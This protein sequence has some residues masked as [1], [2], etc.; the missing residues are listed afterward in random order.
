MPQ[1]QSPSVGI[2]ITDTDAAHDFDPIL[3]AI[4]TGST[5]PARSPSRSA[6]PAVAYNTSLGW[7]PARTIIARPIDDAG[8]DHRRHRAGLLQLESRS[9]VQGIGFIAQEAAEV[10]PE[11]VSRRRQATPSTRTASSCGQCSDGSELEAIL[12]AEIKALRARVAALEAG[13][14]RS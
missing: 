8:D 13:G 4:V 10:V 1:Y 9:E 11:A 3:S 5:L 14:D 6:S 7:S 12:V 2:R